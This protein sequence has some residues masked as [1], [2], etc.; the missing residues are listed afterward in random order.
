[1]MTTTWMWMPHRPRNRYCSIRTIQARKAKEAL[2]ISPSK[3]RTACHGDLTHPQSLRSFVADH[4]R[5]E[6]YRPNTLDDVSGHQ[7]ILATINKF[8]DTNV[9]GLQ[10]G[11]AGEADRAKAITT[12]P[13]IRST[14]DREN[15]HGLSPSATDIR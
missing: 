8:V 4:S 2:L 15:I 11:S 13:P 10:K 5:V 7:D 6:K 9:C 1:M 12:S 3:Q 14:R